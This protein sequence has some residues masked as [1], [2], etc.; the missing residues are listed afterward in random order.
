[1]DTNFLLD[2]VKMVLI[3]G[4]VTVA[5]F[6]LVYFLKRS[7][8]NTL[9]RKGYPQIRL[10]SSLHL[11]PK[12]SVSLVEVAGNWLV[13]GVGGDTVTLLARLDKPEEEMQSGD[14]AN[15]S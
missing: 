4:V 13:L 14:Q 15:E 12:K 8:F 11:G 2:V 9:S 3:L 10:I 6:A 7:R 1:M 5:I